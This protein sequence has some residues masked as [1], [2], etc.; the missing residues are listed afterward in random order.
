MPQ[1][2]VEP[3]ELL[4]FARKFI[5]VPY[6]FGAK[7]KLY[8]KPQG[9]YCYQAW[10]VG[11]AVRLVSKVLRIDCSGFI[12]LVYRA[13]GI[14]LPHGSYFQVRSRYTR[15]C[16]VMEALASAGALLFVHDKRK[17][18]IVHVVMSNGEG[19]IIEANGYYGKVIERKMP[20]GYCNVA[21]LVQR[22]NY[23]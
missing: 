21:R 9:G 1:E 22:V 5:G 2:R 23:V 15:P 7:A 4:S 16:T 18:R 14:E 20:T 12:Y 3:Q 13:K 6:K 10:L 17:D 19:G 8:K 11:G